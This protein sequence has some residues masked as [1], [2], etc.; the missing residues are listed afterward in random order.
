M[1]MPLYAYIC[2]TCHQPL[3][4]LAHGLTNC[5]SCGEPE[6]KRDYRSVQL[7]PVMQEHYNPSVNK[8]ISS[9]RQL[10]DEFKRSSDEYSERTGIEARFAPL[11][12]KDAGA[13]M[14]GM[15]ATNDRRIKQGLK[16]VEFG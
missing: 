6:L 1:V 3:E 15:D 14:E 9:M 8:H 7:S 12:P 11:D 10:S 5:P 16:P 4:S 2:K 13:T